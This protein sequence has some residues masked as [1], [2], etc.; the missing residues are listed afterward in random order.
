MTP[1]YIALGSNLQN[2]ARQLARAVAASDNY[3]NRV[4]RRVQRLSQCRRGPRDQP[5]Y[6]NAVLHCMTRLTPTALLDALQRIEHA[7]GR[8]RGERW[9]ARTLDL[10]ILLYGDQVSGEP[11]ADRYPIPA[12]RQ[13]NF[14]L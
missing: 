3:R 6:L 4:S 12:M 2:P 11:A 8:V 10:D 9:G 1:A 14:V 7:Q 5:D 13:R